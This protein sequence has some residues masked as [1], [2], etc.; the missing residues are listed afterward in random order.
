MCFIVFP[1]WVQEEQLGIFHNV[2]GPVCSS[3]YPETKAEESQQF[4][5]MGFPFFHPLIETCRD[6][7]CLVNDPMHLKGC[8]LPKQ[9]ACPLR[10]SEEGLLHVP[11][12]AENRI[13]KEVNFYVLVPQL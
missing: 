3:D 1:I 9:S 10:L 4:G 7:Q 5:K 13:T 8:L 2:I 12:M 11:S 6:V